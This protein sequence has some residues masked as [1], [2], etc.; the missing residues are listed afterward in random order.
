M[1]QKHEHA[2]YTM[3]I[4]NFTAKNY[5]KIRNKTKQAHRLSW[6]IFKSQY[7]INKN[8]VQDN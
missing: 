1:K 6:D 2:E 3:Y 5:C 4:N 7:T 8:Y